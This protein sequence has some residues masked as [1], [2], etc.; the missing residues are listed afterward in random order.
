MLILRISSGEPI[1][2]CYHRNKITITTGNVGNLSIK[3]KFTTLD[4]Y[5]FRSVYYFIIS[6]QNKLSSHDS[7]C[8][9]DYTATTDKMY[10]L[11]MFVTLIHR[12]LLL[13]NVKS[14][15]ALSACVRF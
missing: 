14:Q 1:D 13:G 10:L 8:T 12:L 3:P 4:A 9:R 5:A 7:Q 11:T 2:K 6:S 15:P